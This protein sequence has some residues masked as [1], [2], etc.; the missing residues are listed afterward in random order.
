M[1]RTETNVTSDVL[2]MEDCMD[3]E[4]DVTFGFWLN[5]IGITVIGLMGIFGNVASIR[6]LSDR[7]MRS[8]VNFILIALAASDLILIVTSILL[9]GLTTIF[10]YNGE[11]KD[12][13]FIIQPQI[14]GIVYPLATMAQTISVYMTFLISLER[15]IA[16]CHALKARSLCTQS[17][18]KHCIYFITL[19]SLLYNVP[20]VFEI[21]LIEG[22]DEDFGTFYCV[23]ASSL[24][25]NKVYITVYIHWL[26]FIFMNLIPL[27]GITYFNLMI[28]CK[29]R[30]VNR[31]RL[32]L[33]NKEMQDIKLTSMLFCV[34]TVFLS[35]NF[36]ACLTN[37]LE[38]IWKIHN[39]RLTK[40]S[41]F[42][43]TLNS[44]VNFVI[45]VVL[46]KK[47]R[48]I[49]IKQLEALFCFRKTEDRKRKIHKHL[50][51]SLLSDSDQT[52]HDYV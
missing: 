11:A 52:T 48:K 18:T 4:A 12:Y 25:I 33:T 3:P 17:R 14:S 41:N 47:F 2:T 28:Y 50:T 46:V 27:S 51:V 40:T 1:N 29:V 9:F 31:L 49:F 44:S 34:V 39:D 45:Y 37:I 8:S 10:P 6:V 42:F 32:K 13:F 36:L 20:K 19:V 7:R 5:G 26:Y 16:V 15:Y 23:S 38:S 24:R 35:C 43:V 21:K 30:S 22:T